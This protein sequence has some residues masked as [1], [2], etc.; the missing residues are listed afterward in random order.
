MHGN[1]L[2][3]I[4]SVAMVEGKLKTFV[5]RLIKC[6]E[7]SKQVVGETGK[8]AATRAAL[9]DVTFLYLVNI[10]QTYGAE[11]VLEEH[12]E[13]Y[14]ES[15][16]R[17]AMVDR[18]KLKSPMTIVR[19]CDQVKVDELLHVY[20][21]GGTGPSTTMKWHEIAENI[22]GMLYQVLLAWENGLTSMEV[23]VIL[24]S[25]RAKMGVYSVCAASWLSAYMYA[26]NEDEHEKP[27]NMIQQLLAPLSVGPDGAE[28][29]DRSDNVKER[30]G[31]TNQIIRRMQTEFQSRT[32]AVRLKLPSNIFPTV[33]SSNNPLE[34]S[35]NEAW[36]S[37][38][39]RKWLSVE[40]AQTLEGLY[41]SC[42]AFWL[43]QRLVHELDKCKYAT[44]IDQVSS[45]TFY[46]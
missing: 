38:S 1:S 34:E 11:T 25:M 13:S 30:L 44:E 19:A 23:K 29:Q 7:C 35:F 36:K 32:T 2:D 26:I 18:R 9:F 10:V 3:L 12:G 17:H 16:V 27:L 14:F 41:E 28:D 43:V 45:L 8:P 31:L 46:T 39:E 37:I 4:L 42:G 40:A 33:L 24:D 22:P 20:L 15:W 6:N 21:N 5:N